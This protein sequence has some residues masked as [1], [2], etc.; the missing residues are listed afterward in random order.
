MAQIGSKNNFLQNFADLGLRSKLYKDRLSREKHQKS[1]NKII[2][3]LTKELKSATLFKDAD[4]SLRL[5]R[6]CIGIEQRDYAVTNEDKK[7]LDKQISE[8]GAA[9]QS[10]IFVS[11]RDIYNSHIENLF[12]KGIPNQLPE[13]DAYI[14]H[15]RRQIQQLGQ[16]QKGMATAHEKFFFQARQENLRAGIAAFK[17]LQK[18]ALFP[19]TQGQDPGQMIAGRE[20]D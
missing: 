13:G 7:R 18:A 17:V 12:P 10:L 19:P 20:N 2:E 6:I 14:T 15:A 3:E 1:F 9:E 8:S 4:I 5:E 16:A 11:N